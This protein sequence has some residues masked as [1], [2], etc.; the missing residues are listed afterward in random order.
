MPTSCEIGNK[1]RHAIPLMQTKS[2]L[3]NALSFKTVINDD[4]IART[5][6]KGPGN[7]PR[8]RAGENR[9]RATVITRASLQW[10]IKRLPTSKPA[11]KR[12]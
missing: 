11:G 1:H 12:H 2:F 5:N 6:S 3:T 10:K 9:W 7:K 8:Y 4:T